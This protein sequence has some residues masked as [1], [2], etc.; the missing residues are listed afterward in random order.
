MRTEHIDENIWEISLFLS[1]TIV[2]ETMYNSKHAD[3]LKLSDIEDANTEKGLL[4]AITCT[5]IMA[6][7]TMMQ[8]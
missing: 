8:D 7:K 1:P 3:A 5:Q 2:K 6:D 4:A